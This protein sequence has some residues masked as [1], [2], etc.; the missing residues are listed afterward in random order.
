MLEGIPTSLEVIPQIL[1]D[2]FLRRYPVPAYLPRSQVSLA[3]EQAQVLQTE[4]TRSRRLGE[5]DQ[6]LAFQRPP[7]YWLPSKTLEQAERRW[8]VPD[9]E[10]VDDDFREAHGY[11]IMNVVNFMK[12]STCHS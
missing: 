7:I 5:R 4:S 12:E 3:R 1:G 6:F 11:D 9:T 8:I 2:C 10:T